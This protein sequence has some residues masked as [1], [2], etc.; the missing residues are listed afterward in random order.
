M[1]ISIS[2][3]FGIITVCLMLYALA[4]DERLGKSED[5]Y[6]NQSCFFCVLLFILFFHALSS[7][8]IFF[9]PFEY[10]VFPLTGALR[11]CFVLS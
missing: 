5:L 9:F 2:M 1:R 11:T 3:N 10:G 4:C 7:D 6:K 8:Y